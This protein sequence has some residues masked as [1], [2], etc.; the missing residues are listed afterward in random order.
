MRVWYHLRNAMTDLRIAFIVIEIFLHLSI[1][2]PW[3]WF[4]L[5]LV[6]KNTNGQPNQCNVRPNTSTVWLKQARFFKGLYDQAIAIEGVLTESECLGYFFPNSTYP[7]ANVPAA[8]WHGGAAVAPPPAPAARTAPRAASVRARTRARVVSAGTATGTRPWNRHGHYYWPWFCN[9]AH[10]H[11]WIKAHL[12][13]T[14]ILIENEIGNENDESHLWNE[15]VIDWRF[16]QSLEVMHSLRQA[17]NSG[18]INN[19][20]WTIKV[21]QWQNTIQ[22]QKVAV[23]LF[24]C[25]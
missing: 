4:Y 23:Y 2:R 16:S 5:Q 12:T 21:K 10:M 24:M 3:N 6:A 8:I 1:K 25:L 19:V 20:R 17:V 13:W 18:Q 7:V 11:T 9:C 15:Q 14:L 22:N